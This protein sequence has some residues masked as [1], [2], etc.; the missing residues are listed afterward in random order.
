MSKVAET[1]INI[2]A[3]VILPLADMIAAR[4]ERR[5]EFRVRLDDKLR[6]LS[7]EE[8]VAKAE[9]ARKAKYDANR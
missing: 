6:S 3:K 9:E 7:I 8:A 2:A 1:F 5:Q 4:R